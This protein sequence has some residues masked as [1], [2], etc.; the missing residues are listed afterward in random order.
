MVRKQSNFHPE[1]AENSRK[2]VQ[3][4]T[5]MDHDRKMLEMYNLQLRT[6]G[7]EKIFSDLLNKIFALQYMYIF[8]PSISDK[9]VSITSFKASPLSLLD[10][11]SSKEKAAAQPHC[12]GRYLV[13]GVGGIM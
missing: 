11:C 1:I 10:V 2:E 12:E 5:D 8:S 3:N 9:L 13:S 7:S 6:S 4:C